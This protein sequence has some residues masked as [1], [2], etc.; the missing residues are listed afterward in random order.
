MSIYESMPNSLLSETYVPDV[1]QKNIYAIDYE[2][3]KKAKIKVVS[4]DIDDTIAPVEKSAPDVAATAFIDML[5]G[6][7]FQVMLLTKTSVE[8]AERLSD[9]YRVDC[10]ACEAPLPRYFE[11]MQNRYREKNGATLEREQIA[12]IGN[13]MLSDI[14]GA[15]HFGCISCLV[16]NACALSGNSGKSKEHELRAVLLKKRIWRKHHLYEP[17]D[18]YYQLYDTHAAQWR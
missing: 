17:E 3:L 9:K 18:Q 14:A 15:N 11:Q 5:N 13:N 8:Q 10:I 2:Q 12:H 6:M 16:R 4:F 7:G 1:Y